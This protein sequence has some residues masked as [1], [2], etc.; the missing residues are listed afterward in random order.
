MNMYN[1]H[2]DGDKKS[3]TDDIIGS[4]GIVRKKGQKNLTKD[5]N[6]Q[7]EIYELKSKSLMLIY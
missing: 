1:L 6:I 2:Y 4:D 7:T 3:V 5:L